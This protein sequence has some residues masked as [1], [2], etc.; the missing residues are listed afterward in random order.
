MILKL[1]KKCLKFFK[2]NNDK[3]SPKIER[4]FLKKDWFISKP[5][6]ETYELSEDQNE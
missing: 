2:E 3:V 4:K 1:L 5:L 6:V